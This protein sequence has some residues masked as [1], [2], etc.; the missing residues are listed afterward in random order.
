MAEGVTAEGAT[1]EEACRA[2]SMELQ[3]AE[4]VRVRSG[5]AAS[6]ETGGAWAAVEQE[7]AVLVEAGAQVVDGEGMLEEEAADEVLC[8]EGRVAQVV[9][10]TSAEVVTAVDCEVMAALV[11]VVP[12]GVVTVEVEAATVAEEAVD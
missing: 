10:E 8:Q 5:V 2:Q 1:V 7:V 4:Q 3:V 9:A 6:V 12:V 11:G